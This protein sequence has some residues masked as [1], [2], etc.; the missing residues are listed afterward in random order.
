MFSYRCTN[1][2]KAICDD[3]EKGDV[4]YYISPEDKELI[5]KRLGRSGAINF[6]QIKK[7]KKTEMYHKR[8]LGQITAI[9]K[10]FPLFE[11]MPILL[12]K[13]AKV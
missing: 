6:C 8:Q 3:I 7:P 4:L 1:A 12:K 9:Q 5:I 2:V 10:M 13:F 11:N